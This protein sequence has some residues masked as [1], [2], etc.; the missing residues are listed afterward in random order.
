M[1]AISLDSWSAGQEVVNVPIERTPLRKESCLWNRLRRHPDFTQELPRKLLRH[2]DAAIAEFCSLGVLGRAHASGPTLRYG[3]NSGDTLVVRA[4]PGGRKGAAG[5]A[6]DGGSVNRAFIL[7]TLGINYTTHPQW[8]KAVFDATDKRGVNVVFENVA[9]ATWKDSIS[10]LKGDGWLVT[11]GSTSG[12]VGETLI[13]LVFWQ[14]V[15]IIGSTM[16]N[17]RE[18]N[19]VMRLFFAGRLK[20]ILDE[21]VPLKDGAA[22]QAR[23]TEGKQCGKIVV[24]P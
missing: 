7:S 11:C 2:Q 21:V 18:F 4:V 23:L 22:A 6:K 24:T 10:S 9:A 12:P 5:G 17:R 1:I 16:E 19:D 20:A 13:P 14:Q 15:H 3:R 8:A